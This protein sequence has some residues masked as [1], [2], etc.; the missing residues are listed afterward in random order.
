MGRLIVSMN[1]S[2]DGFIEAQGQDDGSWLSI[3]EEVHLVFN[4]LAAGAETLLYGR[5]VYEVMIP[6]WPE[7]ATDATRP[8]HERAYGQTWVEKPK[9]VVSTTLKDAG[10][11]TRVVSADPLEEIARLRHASNGDVLCYGGAQLV[12]ALQQRGLVDEYVLFVHPC[13]LGAGVPFF[14]ERVDL[15]LLE[16]RRF[17]NGAVQHRFAPRHDSAIVGPIVAGGTHV[18]GPI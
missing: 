13:A 8:S 15:T 5:K 9:V 10:W 17:E 7:A 18:A 12:S 16:V 4:A 3:D 11:N 1:L 6:Y 2:F 14:R